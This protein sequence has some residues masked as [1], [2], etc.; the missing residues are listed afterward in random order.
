[1]SRQSTEDFQGSDTILCDSV[2]MDTC[3]Y[4]CVQTDGMYTTKNEL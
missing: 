2:M 3:H 1:M 4:A